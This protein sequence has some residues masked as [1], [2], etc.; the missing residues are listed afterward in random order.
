MVAG[1]GHTANLALSRLDTLSLPGDAAIV[2]AG[3]RF[4]PVG[5]SILFEDRLFDN[6]THFSGARANEILL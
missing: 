4:G 5:L 2:G 6:Q 3:L 1:D